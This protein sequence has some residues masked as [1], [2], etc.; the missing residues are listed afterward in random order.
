MNAWMCVEPLR[1]VLQ[2]H[3]LRAMLSQPLL[4]TCVACLRDT[5]P[6]CCLSHITAAPPGIECSMNECIFGLA[7][8]LDLWPPEGGG[9]MSA[10]GTH[11]EQNGHELR[12]STA[13]M[14]STLSQEGDVKLTAQYGSHECLS[15]AMPPALPPRSPMTGRR[16]EKLKESNADTDVRSRC[17][18]LSF[19]DRKGKKGDTKKQETMPEVPPEKDY[20]TVDDHYETV[21][22]DELRGWAK[23]WRRSESFILV[24]ELCVSY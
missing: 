16:T 4:T 12:L 17:R 2:L 15:S 8:D 5:R 19:R 21:D 6:C 22:N 9:V 3:H 1:S 7:E 13:S 11:A 10:E 20:V 23:L 14:S 18:S 24:S